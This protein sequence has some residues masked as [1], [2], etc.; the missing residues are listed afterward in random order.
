MLDPN[1]K[2]ITI[3]ETLIM[4]DEEIKRLMAKNNDN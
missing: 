4:M 1:I 3:I 2:N